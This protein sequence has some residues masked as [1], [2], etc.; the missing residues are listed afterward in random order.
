[1]DEEGQFRYPDA[2]S[3]SVRLG[4]VRGLVLAARLLEDR[5]E[6]DERMRDALDDLRTSDLL[7]EET[8]A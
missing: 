3:L 7:R 5:D 4:T 8:G 2:V 6:L 1:M